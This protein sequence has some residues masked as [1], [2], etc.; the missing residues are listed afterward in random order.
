VVALAAAAAAPPARPGPEGPVPR[1]TSCRNVL[2]PE[3]DLVS[4]A[5]PSRNCISGQADSSK[6]AGLGI[7]GRN[8]PQVFAALRKITTHRRYVC[9]R[10][11]GGHGSRS[12][13]GRY[14]RTPG[15][16][17]GCVPR[18]E[19]QIGVV[20][21]ASTARPMPGR[22]PWAGT[23]AHKLNGHFMRLTRQ[24]CPKTDVSYDR[25]PDRQCW[26][27]ACNP[28]WDTMTITG[29]G[30]QQIATQLRETIP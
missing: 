27:V 28:I 9:P 18:A 2:P 3:S 12:A 26:G 23:S 20:R 24:K 17:L 25:R 4:A 19:P 29:T 8:R 6:C 1:S 15:R 11:R 14:H 10:S 13:D 21:P 16:A 5:D 7:S 22:D 30:W